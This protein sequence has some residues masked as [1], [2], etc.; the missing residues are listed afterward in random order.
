MLIWLLG[1]A[2]VSVGSMVNL[3]N[4]SLQK[5]GNSHN[6]GKKWRILVVK[7]QFMSLC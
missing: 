4:F 6:L 7:C 5:S 2:F 3:R 1:G